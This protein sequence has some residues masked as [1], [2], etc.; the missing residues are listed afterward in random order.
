MAGQLGQENRVRT[1][2]TE[3]KQKEG[4]NMTRQDF[5]TGQLRKDN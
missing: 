2:L 5:W 3:N 4:Q 1:A